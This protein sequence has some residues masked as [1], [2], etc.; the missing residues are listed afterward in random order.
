MRSPLP[1]TTLGGGNDGDLPVP[2]SQG[3]LSKRLRAQAEAAALESRIIALS[4]NLERCAATD[5]RSAGWG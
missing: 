2:P 4:I 5:E 1:L 3:L